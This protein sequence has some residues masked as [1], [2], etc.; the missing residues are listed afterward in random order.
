GRLA[1][2]APHQKPRN[3]AM[4]ATTTATAPDRRSIQVTEKESNISTSARPRPK[5]R[6]GTRVKMLA[7]FLLVG[8][9]ATSAWWFLTKNQVSTD[10]ATIEGHVVQISPKIASHVKAIYFN[11]NYLV[12]QGD[13]LVELDAR[14]FDV[15]LTSA[16]ANLASAQS[17][18]AEARAQRQ[19][20]EATLGQA[21]A[22]LK[23]AQA[24]LDNAAADLKRNEQL[25][26]THVID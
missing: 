9:T 14:D 15:S 2:P 24:T 22:D 3:F 4:S 11:D 23:S 19:L 25:F 20:A 17:R 13:L 21:Q 10:D 18:V 12:K 5:R 7:A 1:S 16:E 26:A 8:A 6:F